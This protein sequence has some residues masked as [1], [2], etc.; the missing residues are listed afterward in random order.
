MF[1]RI[2]ESYKS[3]EKITST[4]LKNGLKFSLLLCVI[5]VLILLTYNLIISAPILFYIGITVFR[6]SL[7]FGIEFIVCSF[8]VDGIKK[9]LI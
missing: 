3:F 8:V 1:K 2:L 7:V 5:S 4:I 6:L 9:Q